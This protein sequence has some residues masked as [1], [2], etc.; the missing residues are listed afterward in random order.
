MTHRPN[1]LQTAPEFYRAM[2]TLSDYVLNCGIENS[3]L[4]LV[5]V[6]ASQINGCAFCLDMHAREARKLG[7]ADE[8]I[9]MLSAWRDAGIYSER[10]K[11]A[12]AWTEA[13]TLIAQGPV[14]DALFDATRKHFSEKEIVDLT[15]AVTVING[16]NRM[17]ATFEVPPM[18]PAVKQ[19]AE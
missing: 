10:E 1:P 2:K 16:W 14:S 5:K 13:V 6:R 11:A 9:L 8:K 19:A 12:F 3:L 4:E 7:E 18:K 15:W 17:M